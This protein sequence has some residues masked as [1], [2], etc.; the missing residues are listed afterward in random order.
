ME[1]VVDKATMEWL[2]AQKPSTRAQYKYAWKYFL[3]YAQMTGDQILESRKQD[4][5]AEWERKVVNAKAWCTN[6]GLSDNTAKAITTA[7]RSFFAYRRVKLEFITSEKTKL[8]EAEPV[9]EDYRFTLEDFKRM[10]EVADLTERYVICGGKSFGLRS[11][12]FN[13]RLMRGDFDPVIN[14][15]P[16]I[17]VGEKAT[18][19]EKVPA[20]LFIN[21]DAKPVI[22]AM[23][24][25]M[26]REG[27]TA[28]TERMLTYSDEEELSRIIQRLVVKAGINIGNKRVR[29]HCMR[30]WL[31]D[32]LA[33]FMSE[34][35]W[36][37]VVGKKIKEG[38]YVGWETLREDY[39]RAMPETTF[40]KQTLTDDIAQLAKLEALKALAKTMGISE[41][42]MSRMFKMRKADSLTEQVVAMENLIKLHSG[43]GGNVAA[44]GLSYEK[45][46]AEIIDKTLAEAVRVMQQELKAA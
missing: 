17:F 18:G 33:R 9:Y 13:S 25:Q 11:G 15:E 12:D 6:R 30:K 29:F 7:A 44:G 3:E 20:Y 22:K 19:K 36:K 28:P 34:S 46:Q 40:S 24:D 14:G 39:K 43:K 32:Q 2:N 5:E 26:T 21:V 41:A 23:L 31:S 35:K 16:P 27:R 8:T 45:R 42:Q 1:S 38:A 37:Q 4:T 10:Y